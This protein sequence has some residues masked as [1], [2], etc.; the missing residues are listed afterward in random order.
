MTPEIFIGID[1]SKAHL[2]VAVLP[3][4]ERL[5]LPRDPE[6]ID[7]LLSHLRPLSPTLVI[8]EA[9]GGL[10]APV[11]SSLAA[12]SL[13]VVVINP[14]QA[15]DFAKA[16]GQ[17]AKTD[18]LD[19]LVLARF[20][21]A[22]RPAVRPLADE[23]TVALNAQIVRR[24]QLINMIVAEQNRLATAPR[25]IQTDI[26]AHIHWLQKKL[27][28]L[29]HDLQQAIQQSPIWREKDNLLQSAPGVGPTLAVTLLAGLPELGRLDR[30]KIAALVGVA[31]LNRDSGTF[32]GQRTTWGGRSH[33]RS[34]LYM[35]AMSAIRFNPVIRTFYQRLRQSGKVP[36]LALVAC[37]RKLLTIL[38]SMIKNR[39]PWLHSTASVA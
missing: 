2:D 27:E 22:V 29:D 21:Q 8:L 9:T 36:K 12:D 7:T 14:R 28:R 15:R 33:I 37:M 31:P 13:P 6:G 3:S 32:R 30:K 10:E 20:G 4:G 18:A 19:A 17:L 11:A 26:Q 23:Q 39:T 38:N 25:P 1:V 16:T 5:S 35:A 24:R 34:V